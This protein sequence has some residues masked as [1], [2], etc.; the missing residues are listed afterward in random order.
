[1][2]LQHA[3]VNPID[4]RL[5]AGWRMAVFMGAFML[6]DAGVMA[7]VFKLL[8]AAGITHSDV[9][10]LGITYGVL[11]F[12]TWAMCAIVERR[13]LRAVGFGIHE[14]T[15]IELGQG[16]GLGTL[17]MAAIFGVN[18][19]FG[20]ASFSFKMLTIGQLV[21]IVGFG[22]I[23]FAIV[24]FGEE[25]LFR[26]YLF[27]TLVEGSSRLIAV[28]VFALFFAFVHMKNPDVTVFSLVNIA[29]AGVWLSAAYFKTRGLWMP[30]GLHFSWNFF[31]STIFSFPVSGLKLYDKQ[32]GV[33]YDNGPTWLTGG[34]FGPEGGAMATVMLVAATVLIWFAPQVRPSAAA[35]IYEPVIAPVIEEAPDARLLT[36]TDD[37]V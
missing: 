31:Q 33:L 32:I 22:I 6:V 20:F 4:M 11:L 7:G 37:A 8:T 5:R 2:K 21:S 10:T 28:L 30:I 25:L 29:I 1:M 34:T 16:I 3:F 27:Q 13:P 24:G 23:E 36:E 14:R 9:L 15:W 26:G 12:V 19:M 17:M 18:I 35:W